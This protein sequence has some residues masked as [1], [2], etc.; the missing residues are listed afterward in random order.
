MVKGV[1]GRF[2]I[3]PEKVGVE[4]IFP[5]SAPQRARLDLGQA[6]VAQRKN[7]ERLE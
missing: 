2:I 5:G 4:H 7:R 3:S 1:A 6:D